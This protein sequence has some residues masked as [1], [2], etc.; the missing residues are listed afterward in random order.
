M[1]REGNSLDSICS[2][3]VHELGGIR[4]GGKPIIMLFCFYLYR[5]WVIFGEMIELV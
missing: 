3:L 1:R 5:N 2:L 4:R